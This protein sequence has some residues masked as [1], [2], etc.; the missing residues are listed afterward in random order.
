MDIVEILKAIGTI[1]GGIVSVVAPALAFVKY[2]V[3][4]ELKRLE[5]GAALAQETQGKVA[6]Q[7]QKIAYMER[8]AKAQAEQI[9]GLMVRMQEFRGNYLTRFDALGKAQAESEKSIIAAIHGIQVSCAA[10][11]AA[12][13]KDDV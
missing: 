2:L 11:S 6:L 3:N 9:E 7:E 4:K 1:I 5:D 12:L 8:D 13:R 10:H